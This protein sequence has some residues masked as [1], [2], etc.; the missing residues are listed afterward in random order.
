MILTI[1]ICTVI[2]RHDTYLPN[3]LNE[4]ENQLTDD[5]EILYLGDNRLMTVGEKRNRLVDMAQGEYIAFIDDDDRIASDYIKSVLTAL[6][7]LPDVVTFMAEFNDGT[8][9]KK[10]NYSMSYTKDQ[11][12]GPY[13]ERLPNHL[14]VWRTNLVKQRGFPHNRVGEDAVFARKIKQYVESRPQKYKEV[15]ID[16]ILYYYDMNYENSETIKW[17]KSQNAKLGQNYKLK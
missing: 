6:K 15:H 12:R 2:G 11:T 7:S 13:F 14:C 17:L 3:I 8:I 1:G 9:K 5:V 16:K 4:I 10:V